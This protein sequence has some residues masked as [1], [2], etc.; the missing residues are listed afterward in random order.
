[1]TKLYYDADDDHTLTDGYHVRGVI[2]S[3]TED[4][5]VKVWTSGGAI[6]AILVVSPRGGRLSSTSPKAAVN[7]TLGVGL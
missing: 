3:R 1:M 6:A 7:P 4:E 5:T 2:F